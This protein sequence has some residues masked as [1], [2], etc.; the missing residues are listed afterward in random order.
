MMNYCEHAFFW[1]CQSSWVLFRDRDWAQQRYCLP[2]TWWLEEMQLLKRCLKRIKETDFT[3]ISITLSYIWSSYFETFW[4]FSRGKFLCQYGSTWP[5]RHLWADCLEN[6]GSST[7]HSPI[8]LHGLLKGHLY[9]LLYFYGS[10]W[11]II[12]W[13]YLQ[14]RAPR[15]DILKNVGCWISHNAK[16]LHSLLQR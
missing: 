6:V 12:L 7:S 5:H 10:T 16:G 15:Y 4:N 9:F 3:K 13:S 11:R 2:R 14:D 8:G 1:I